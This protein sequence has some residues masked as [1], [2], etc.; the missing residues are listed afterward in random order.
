MLKR[1]PRPTFGA[2]IGLLTIAAY[3]AGA[4]LAPLLAPFGEYQVIGPPFHEGV[5]VIGTDNLGRDLLSRLIYGARNSMGIAIVTTAL[6]FGIGV[7]GGF[8]AAAV[9][10]VIDQLFGRIVDVILAMPFLIFALLLLTIFGTSTWNLIAIMAFLDFP[11]V[12][13]LARA[14]ALNIVALDFVEAARVRGERLGWILFRE[15]LPNAAAP[16]LAEFGLRFTFVFLSISALSFIGLGI[17]PPQADWGS[18]VRDNAKLITF[19][20]LTPL[21]PAAAIALLTLAVNLVVDWIL[22]N[23]REV[24]N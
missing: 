16:L 3:C 1:L 9:G 2:A 20:V 10:G 15:I 11:R 17:Q 12:F 23:D 4:V 21:F 24:R 14:V 13:R 7:S 8:I 5:G 18:M 6:S 22:H 19:G